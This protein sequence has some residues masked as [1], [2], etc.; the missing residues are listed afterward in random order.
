[1]NSEFKHLVKPI[2]LIIILLVLFLSIFKL[3]FNQIN[4]IMAKTN[5]SKETQ[6]LLTSKISILETVNETIANDITYVDIALP[7]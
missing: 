6:R 5:E 4:L 1:M 7:S 3:G 2:S